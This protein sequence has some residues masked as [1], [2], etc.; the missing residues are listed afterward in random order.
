MSI[1]I[2][3]GQKQNSHVININREYYSCG[4]AYLVDVKSGEATFS[5]PCVKHKILTVV[6]STAER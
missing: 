1:Q 5:F 6:G 4:C 2:K 3:T